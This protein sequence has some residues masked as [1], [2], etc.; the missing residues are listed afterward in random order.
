[1]L[2]RSF[3]IRSLALATLLIGGLPAQAQTSPVK[4]EYFRAA[5]F[6]MQSGTVLKEVVVEYAT[7][8]EPRRDAAGNIINAVINPHGWS[9]NYLQTLSIGKDL[10]GPGRPLDPGKYFIIFPTAMGSPGSSS[11]SQSGMAAKFPAYTVADMVHAQY[12][13]VTE[14]YGIKKLAG[15]IGSSM[16]GYQTLQW[17]TQYPDMMG[18]AVP[19]AASKKSDGRNLGIFGMMSF[20]IRSDPAYMN[21]DYK[22]QPKEGMRRGF[23]STYLWYFSTAFY[24]AQY[25]TEEQVLKGLQD[26][27][28]GSDKMDANDIIWRNNA[29]A[30]YDVSAGLSK[31]KAKVLVVGVVEDEL[32]PPKEA[33]QPI[34]DA[35]PGAKTFFYESVL[36][37]LGCAVHIGKA[38]AAIMQHIADAEKR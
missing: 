21:G 28:L 25:K 23:M 22:E 33:I 26:A 2:R 10:V 13:L 20:N 12:R 15:V 17:M 7:L 18:W 9:G 37:H 3:F 24:D 35:I 16:G 19:I 5:D 29:M 38:N 6:K 11:P 4:P 32:F 30:T 1:M 34:A 31:V 36:G 14:R 27:G 8:G